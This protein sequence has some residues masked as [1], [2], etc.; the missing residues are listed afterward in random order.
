MK[1]VSN[2]LLRLLLFLRDHPVRLQPLLSD[3]HKYK[4]ASLNVIHEDV[5]RM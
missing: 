4:T 5:R 2:R 3:S 1:K